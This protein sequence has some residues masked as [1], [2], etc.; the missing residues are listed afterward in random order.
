MV[1]LAGVA[2]AHRR[3]GPSS[4]A[5]TSTTW[6]ALPSSATQHPLLE[7]PHDHDAAAL[8]QRLAGM[9]GLV[10]PHDHREER[11][12]LL[13]TARHGHPEH[14]PGDPTLGVPELGVVGQV[15]GE[16]H[17]CLGHDSALLDCLA[18]RSA[19]PLEPG[20]GGHRGM[21]GDRRR[22]AMEPTKSAMYQDC[23]PMA[24]SGAELVGGALAAGVGHA[25]T[26]RPDPST[27]G[28]VGER[29]SRH[30]GRSPA[31]SR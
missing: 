3:L 9:L 17:G 25:S 21:P 14:G 24:G 22:Q 31:R 12:L 16:A 15:A 7:P 28:V 23:R 13:P 26:V 18:G 10:A 1:T 2:V 5:T 4:S 29:G 19:L 8:G 27:L 6:R 11:R 30:E 20:D